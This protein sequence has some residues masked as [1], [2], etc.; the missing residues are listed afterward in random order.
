MGD[1]M[2]EKKTKNFE[3]FCDLIK[4]ANKVILL[5]AFITNRTLNLIKAIDGNFACDRGFKGACPFSGEL[6]YNEIPINKK[7]VFKT[8]L[9][10]SACEDIFNEIKQTCIDEICKSL[11][12]NK[13]V[14]IFYP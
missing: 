7:I 8:A 3:I 2:K 1:F 4:N 13:K 6:L 12:N 11:E 14:F 9:G 10:N 5:D